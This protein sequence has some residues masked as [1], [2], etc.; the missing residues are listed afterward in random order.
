MTI[1]RTR[2]CS[3]ASVPTEPKGKAACGDIAKTITPRQGSYSAS[4]PV[5]L[6]MRALLPAPVGS[7][8][9][10]FTLTCDITGGLLSVALSVGS[11]RPLPAPLLCESGLSSN[12][13]G[14]RPSSPPH[15]RV[16]PFFLWVNDKA[17]SN[18]D[19]GK[20]AIDNGVRDGAKR[21]RTASRTMRDPQDTS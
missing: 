18:V 12:H 11:P 5:G 13:I 9:T 14:P 20:S 17:C 6:A 16:T 7:Y 10:P 15:P 21:N 3:R 8:P 4:L 19:K 2:H 1:H